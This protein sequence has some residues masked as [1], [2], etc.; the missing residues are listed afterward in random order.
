MNENAFDG[1]N[2]TMKLSELLSSSLIKMEMTS[3]DKR[4]VFEE[5]VEMLESEGLIKDREEALARIE[6]REVKM[7]T[8][9]SHWLAMPHG[10]L[11]GLP[12]LAIAAMGISKRG[13]DY[14]ALDYEPVHIVVLVFSEDGH[15]MEHIETLSDILRIFSSDRFI[16]MVCD[17]QSADE[18]LQ[19]IKNEESSL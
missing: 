2:V 13:I 8:G 14:G 6:E 18:V 3:T 1:G 5:L 9:I 15:P 19:L 12:Q 10:K 17:A 4:G 7:S 11:K 16:R